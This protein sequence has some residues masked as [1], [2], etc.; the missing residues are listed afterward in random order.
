[1]DCLFGLV[2][3]TLFVVIV[4]FIIDVC[5]KAVGFSVPPPVRILVGILAGLLVLMRALECLPASG[6]YHIMP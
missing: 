3:F 6:R 4:L 1:M 2:L 5:L